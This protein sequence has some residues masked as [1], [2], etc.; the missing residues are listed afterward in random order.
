MKALWRNKP[1]R[2]WLS[3]ETDIPP[4][5]AWAKV[6]TAS[7]VLVLQ[8]SRTHPKQV[9]LDD[10]PGK[11]CH[12]RSC[13]ISNSTGRTFPFEPTLNLFLL[14]SFSIRQHLKEKKYVW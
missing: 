4:W 7:H 8:P 14:C 10:G 11:H 2:F 13:G 12:W 3:R 9:R 6:A 1:V 5:S